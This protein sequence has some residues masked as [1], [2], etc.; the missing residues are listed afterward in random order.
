MGK[1]GTQV[2][3]EAADI[4]LLDDDFATIVAGVEG[5][6]AVLYRLGRALSYLVGFHVPIVVLALVFPLLDV[7]LLLLPAQLLLLQLIVHPMVALVF[8]G[9]PVPRSLMEVPPPLRLVLLPAR[10]LGRALGL[11]AALTGVAAAWYVV[12]AE[13]VGAGSGA[14]AAGF[15]ALVAAQFA[16]VLACR[17]PQRPAWRVRPFWTPVVTAAAALTTVGLLVVIYVEPVA[18]ALQMRSLPPWLFGAALVTG[19]LAALILEVFRSS[20]VGERRG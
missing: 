16:L 3:R 8:Q 15:V 12:G 20:R 14:R 10:E 13:V 6:R 5:G 2:A 1:R 19:V 18:H 11:G 9:D 7:P 17:D 4:V